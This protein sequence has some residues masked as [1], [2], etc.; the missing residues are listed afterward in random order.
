MFSAV[1]GFVVGS[2]L[3]DG[4][5]QGADGTPNGTPTAGVGVEAEGEVFGTDGDTDY[6]YGDASLEKADGSSLTGH[7]NGSAG[8]NKGTTISATAIAKDSVVEIMTTTTS[9]YGRITA[10]AGSGVIIHADGVIVTNHHV[11]DGATTV[12]VRLTNGNTYEAVVRGSDEDGDVAVIKIQ[13]RETLTVAKMG[14]SAALALGEEVIAIGNPLGQLGGTVTNGIVSAL[15]RKINVDGITMSLI[16]T[17][18]AINSGNS[19]G[20]LFNLAGELIG[21]VNAK[22]AAE[23]VEGLGFAIPVDTAIVSINHLLQL[24][25]IPGIPAL[26]VDIT[27]QTATLNGQRVCMPYVSDA[28]I[29]AALKQGDYIYSVEGEVVVVSYTNYLSGAADPLSL[30]K[31]QIRQHEVGDTVTLVVYR[32]GTATTVNVKLVE[33]I[34]GDGGVNFN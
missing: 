20:G 9:N 32:N 6:D 23:G 7:P 3:A 21:I 26:G 14:S 25:Y 30:L 13:P 31:Q 34:P 28:P 19:G 2:M 33:Y 5:M 18:A 10:G 15:E 22:Y 27:V 4:Y 11:I 12:R 1:A 29:G 17:N 8:D 16:Q 24:G